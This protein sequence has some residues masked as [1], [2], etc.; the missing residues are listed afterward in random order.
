MVLIRRLGR[1]ATML[2][3]YLLVLLA[4]DF[5]V[6]RTGLFPLRGTTPGHE[7]VG[8]TKPAV[9]YEDTAGGPPDI[10]VAI[11]GTRTPFTTSGPP[12]GR[13]PRVTCRTSSRRPI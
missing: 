9:I 12:A 1:A 7:V 5:A 11:I 8:F 3:Y 2:G 4:I 13:T 10:R 6:T